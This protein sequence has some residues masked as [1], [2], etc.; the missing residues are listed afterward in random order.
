MGTSCTSGICESRDNDEKL[1][2][3]KQQII[4]LFNAIPNG[5]AHHN[6][7]KL[8]LFLKNTTCGRSALMPVGKKAGSKRNIINP[9]EENIK[10]MD[11][12]YLYGGGYYE[13]MKLNDKSNN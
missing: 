11:C 8:D 2:V 13:I 9:L 7:S 10:S 6:V 1:N 12:E 5:I 3:H 4:D